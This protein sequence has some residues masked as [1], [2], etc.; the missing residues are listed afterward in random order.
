MSLTFS[1]LIVGLMT[2]LTAGFGALFSLLHLAD[3]AIA[4]SFVSSISLVILGRILVGHY[5]NFTV[6]FL[7]F[8]ALYGLSGPIAA[9][10]GE[11]LPP[12]FSHPLSY[13]GVSILLLVGYFGD[14]VWSLVCSESTIG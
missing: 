14:G 11:G 2:I 8:S 5:T 1:A 10:Y 3:F 9:Q 7:G 4:L 13:G 6:V 12:V